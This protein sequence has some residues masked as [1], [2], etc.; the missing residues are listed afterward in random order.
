MVHTVDPLWFL[1]VDP[2][3]SGARLADSLRKSSLRV[4]LITS[5]RDAF[6]LLRQLP[7]K[8]AVVLLETRVQEGQ[9][10][11]LLPA[12]REASPVSR[13]LVVTAYG[14]IASAVLALQMGAENYLCKPISADAVLQVLQADPQLQASPSLLHPSLDRA[15]WEYIHFVLAEEGTVAGTARRLGLHP[16][17]LRRMLQKTPPPR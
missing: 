8:P 11:R 3:P 12:F 14:S 9:S 4:D 16:R 6:P 5:A 7:V 10:L 17:S 15:I 1:V 2:E 13:F